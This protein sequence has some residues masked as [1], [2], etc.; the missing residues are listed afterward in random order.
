MDLSWGLGNLLGSLLYSPGSTMNPSAGS[1]CRGSNTAPSCSND[2]QPMEWE[3]KCWQFFMRSI[4]TITL[5][6]SY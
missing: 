5:N 4:R 6:F 2:T 1:P 3:G